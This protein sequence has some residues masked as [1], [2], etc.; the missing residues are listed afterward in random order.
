VGEKVDIGG[1]LRVIAART[2]SGQLFKSQRK[3]HP[4]KPRTRAACG[5]V[6]IEKV[7]LERKGMGATPSIKK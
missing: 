7:Y 4:E 1:L 6:M 2:D 5:G 3:A